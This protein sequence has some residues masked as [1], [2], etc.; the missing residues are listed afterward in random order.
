ME[1]EF[2]THISLM[3]A[4]LSSMQLDVSTT[5]TLVNG[6]VGIVEKLWQ[7]CILPN[8][9]FPLPAIRHGNESSATAFGM[10]YLNGVYSPSVAPV[11]LS[12]G[13]SQTSASCPSGRSDMQGTTLAS[14][15]ASSASGHAGPSSAPAAGE[16]HLAVVQWLKKVSQ[17]LWLFM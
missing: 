9:S 13:V 4:E 15:S 16:P 8:P 10:R 5:M 2:D 17:C 3:H 12:A 14:G 6:L 7:E 11:T 1:Y